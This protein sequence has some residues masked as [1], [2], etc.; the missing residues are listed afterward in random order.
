MADGRRRFGDP[1]KA[2][3]PGRG[4]GQARSLVLNSGTLTVAAFCLL[5]VAGLVVASVASYRRGSPEL[6]SAAG[7]ILV[8]VMCAFFLSIAVALVSPRLAGR[9]LIYWELTAVALLVGTGLALLFLTDDFIS[10]RST[11]V[12][13]P[14]TP[15]SAR[16]NGTI[17]LV[18]GVLRAGMLSRRRR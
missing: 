11:G 4:R 5:A 1:R 18:M 3:K 8:T 13:T 7:P 14:E 10:D 6:D 12:R 9:A 2:G 17:L 16:V 15:T